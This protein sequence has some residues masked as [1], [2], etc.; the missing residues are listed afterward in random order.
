MSLSGAKDNIITSYHR[1]AFYSLHLP[2]WQPRLEN[3]LIVLENSKAK[4][5]NRILRP[6]NS[7]ALQLNFDPGRVIPYDLNGRIQHDPGAIRIIG[8][9][10]E[11][12]SLLLHEPFEPTLVYAEMVL[13][14]EPARRDFKCE[15]VCLERRLF[16]VILC[17]RG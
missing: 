12:V 15:V 3:D 6:Q 13:L 8:M 5:H 7:P 2:R 11:L 1:H 17:G 16:T 10:A 14:R 9:A 4:S